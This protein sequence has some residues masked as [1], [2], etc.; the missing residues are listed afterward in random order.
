MNNFELE[1]HNNIM[2]LKNAE[3][4]RLRKSVEG[5]VEREFNLFQQVLELKDHN[6]VLQNQK[7]EWVKKASENFQNLDK[8]RRENSDLKELLIKKDKEIEDL[9][10]SLKIH[11]EDDGEGL[12][13]FC[14]LVNKDLEIFRQQYIKADEGRQGLQCFIIDL[15]TSKEIKSRMNPVELDNSG[16]YLNSEYL[17]DLIDDVNEKFEG[18]NYRA[19]IDSDLCSSTYGW[20]SV[21]YYES[22]S[23]EE[24]E[25]DDES[26]E[27]EENY[28]YDENGNRIHNGDYGIEGGRI[29]PQRLDE[30]NIEFYDSQ[31]DSSESEDDE[32]VRAR[33]AHLL[34]LRR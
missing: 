20:L 29:G 14:E 21:N 3:I 22:S 19:E 32:V 28:E 7:R 16:N 18:W 34:P 9:K 11:T 12:S 2:M 10:L 5:L 1:S 6:V 23:E 8:S 31:D 27:E 15:L 24:E 13:E 25:D 4:D 26:E 30:G 17:S 33:I